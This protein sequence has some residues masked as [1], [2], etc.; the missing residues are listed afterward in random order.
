MYEET[1]FHESKRFCLHITYRLVWLS[2][3]LKQT[4][5]KELWYQLP[6]LKFPIKFIFSKSSGKARS[7]VFFYESGEGAYSSKNLDKQK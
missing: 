5:Y 1:S 6:S 2:K 7:I 4:N 3:Q